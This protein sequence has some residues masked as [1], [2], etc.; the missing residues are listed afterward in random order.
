MN[1]VT[2]KGLL[3]AWDDNVHAAQASFRRVLK[4]LSEP[5]L[6]QRMPVTLAA[7]APFDVATAALC[8]TLADLETP[9]WLDAA[10]RSPAVESYLRFH[11][12]CPL[13]DERAAAQFAVLA[14]PLDQSAQLVLAD[15]TQG[16]MEYPDRSATLLIQVASLDSGPGRL[17]SGPGIPAV[18]T[19]H[20][21]G[22]PDDFDAA[23]QQNHAAFPLGVDIIF[24]CGDAIVGLPRTTT[25]HV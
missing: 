18:R 22:L 9:V 21:A 20:V 24:C 5:G 19:L 6:I 23:W 7:P 3:P 2:D 14:A 12:G 10:M 17:L 1:S 16:S 8:L 4:A 13:I 25:I 11:C 15:F